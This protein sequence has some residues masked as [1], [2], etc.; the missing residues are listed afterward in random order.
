M[1]KE[2]K[3]IQQ[4]AK[5][6]KI[7]NVI[8]RDIQIICSEKLPWELAEL[9]S[10]GLELQFMNSPIYTE[11]LDA[12]REDGSKKHFQNFAHR[13][14]VRLIKSEH[15]NDEDAESLM[16]IEAEFCASYERNDGNEALTSDALEAFAKYNVPFNLWPYW[17]E[18][19]DSTARRMG[20]NNIIIPF[21]QS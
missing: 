7:D 3:L 1:K 4:V 10:K 13:F 12:K 19:A 17:R 14:G 16:Q 15:R 5:F 2:Q 21:Y 9:E 20:I 8:L 11:T 18:L 6:L